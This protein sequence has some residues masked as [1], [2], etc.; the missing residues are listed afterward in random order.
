[1]D[2]G[3]RIRHLR[4]KHGLKQIN[5]A[6][7]LQV[8]PQA[9]SKWERG[10]AH[11]EIP[12][13]L[14][15]AALFDVSTDYLL[16]T[17]APG[18]NVFPATVFCSGLTHFARRSISMNSREVADYTNGLFYHLTE[19]VLKCDGIPVKY[20]GDG[21]LCFFSGIGH[22]DRAV[23]AAIRAKKGIYQKELVIALNTGDIF[24]GMVGHPQYA[25]RDIAGD[26]VN[27]A[28]LILESV[29]RYCLSGI[30]ATESVLRLASKTFA[31]TLHQ[32]VDLALLDTTV[33][34]H[35]IHI[36]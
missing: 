2:I 5:L 6:N 11:P 21:F 9:V 20:V 23:D 15:M 33:D 19:S 27:R 36:P 17:T 34:V 31:T 10:A 25:T 29:S 14:K 12:V 30:G 32:G 35:E 22:A 16:G 26:T 1:M 3:Q 8:S 4:E 18:S 7:A 24:M 28:F 13:L